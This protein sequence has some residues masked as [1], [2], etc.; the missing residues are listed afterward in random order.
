MLLKGA[1]ISDNCAIVA[2]SVISGFV[3][4]GTIVKPDGST[5]KRHDHDICLY[6]CVQL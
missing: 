5:E 6:G 1:Y 3:P 4:E 2:G